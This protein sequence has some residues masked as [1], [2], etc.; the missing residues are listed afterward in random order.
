VTDAEQ[1]AQQLSL[2]DT[3]RS[4][5]S[6][7][8]RQSARARRLSVRVFRHGGVEIVVPPRTSPQ[9]VSAFVSEHREWIERQRRRSAPAAHWPLP[10]R[11]L[12]LSSL[13]ERWDCMPAAGAGRV[14][15][16]QLS[17]R[18]LQLTG[19]IDDRQQLRHALIGWLTR[20][21][22]RR[23]EAPLRALGAQLGVE[24]GRVQVRCQRTRWGSCSRSG[25]ISLN[26]CLLFQTPAVLRYL[27]VHELVHL[28]HMN[29][30]A[31]FWADVA[32]H[33]PDWRA[34]DRE[35]MQGW[36]RVPSWMFR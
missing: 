4:E 20:H 22:E 23:F 21:A 18:L 19:R 26:V 35:L 36:R 12:E 27:M 33:E 9:R 6:W 31:R 8:V 28:R 2:W 10:P 34:L 7:S 14:R 13:G 3:E 17:D 30:S 5:H 29:H 1:K 32:R 16:R 25:T 11:A 24:P 15:L